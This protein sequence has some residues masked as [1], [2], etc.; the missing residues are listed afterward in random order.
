MKKLVLFVSFRNPIIYF[1]VIIM[2]VLSGCTSLMMGTKYQYNYGL[3]KKDSI[4]TEVDSSSVMRFSDNMIVADFRIGATSISFNIQNKTEDVM[5]IIWDKSSIVLFGTS[6]KIIHGEDNYKDR[7]GPQPPTVI[8]PNSDIDDLV[9]PSD[10]ISY[11]AGSYNQYYVSPGEWTENDL[12]PL[13]DNNKDKLKNRILSSKGKF[14]SLYLPIQYQGKTLNYTF[15]F[16]VTSV[17]PIE[18]M[19]KNPKIK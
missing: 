3:I 13:S 9:L 16:M 18:P 11:R 2:T 1:T 8:P 19:K 17:Q 7:S 10:N 12:F 15:N 14:F 5:E 6:H 4:S